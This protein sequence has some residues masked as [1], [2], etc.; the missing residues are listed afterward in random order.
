MTTGSAAISVSA[1]VAVRGRPSLWFTAVRQLFRLA[2]RGWWHRAPFLPVPARE[3]LEF[4]LVTQYGG[5]HGSANA[6]VRAE[7]VVDYLQWCKQ[8]NQSQ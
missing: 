8:W 3:Y 5:G 2:P 7:D 1:V 4:R 6:P